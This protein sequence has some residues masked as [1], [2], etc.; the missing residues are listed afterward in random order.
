MTAVLRVGGLIDIDK[1]LVALPQGRVEHV[2]RA[3]TLNR[4]GEVHTT[5]G[6]NFLLSEVEHAPELVKEAMETFSQVASQIDRLIRSGATAE[7]DF[8][9]FI[10]AGG[11]RSI[12]ID[13]SVLAAFAQHGVSVVVSAYPCSD[14]DE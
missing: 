14:E 13:P 6:F 5:S 9:L 12:R 2:R 11:S 8:A 3:G 10:R 1:C 7:V 4:R